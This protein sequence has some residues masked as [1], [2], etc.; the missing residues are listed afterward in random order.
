MK[1]NKKDMEYNSS[2]IDDILNL[3]SSEEQ[4]KV[5][6]KMRLAAKI[7][8]ALKSQRIKKGE[9]AKMLNQKNQSVITKW[10]SGTHNFTTDTLF[11]LQRVLGI[12]LI[13]LDDNEDNREIVT[14]VHIHVKSSADIPATVS[15]IRANS[16]GDGQLRFTTHQGSFSKLQI[17]A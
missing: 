12:K 7:S 5:D 15:S 11:D 16:V 4:D 8:D 10:L 9:L 1:K 13:N 6:M 2:E 3:I 17:E 14:V